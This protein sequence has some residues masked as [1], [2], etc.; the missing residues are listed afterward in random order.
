MKIVIID[1]NKKVRVNKFIDWL[2]Y[3]VAYALILITVSVL[4][5]KTVYIDNNFFGIWGLLAAI[6][7][8]FLNKTIKPLIVWLTLPL[9]ALTL[10]L[11]YPV[12]NVL[13]LNIVDFILGNHFNITGFI[14]SFIVAILI[15]IMNALMEEII[16]KP[17]LRRVK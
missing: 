13:I 14:M 8:Y 7:I 17:I 11:F 16:I 2:I 15:S 10:G 6:I 3:M 12:I 9:T 4:F 1:E 5:P